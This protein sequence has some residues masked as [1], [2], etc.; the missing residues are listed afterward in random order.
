MDT[1]ARDPSAEA[2]AATMV[3]NPSPDFPQVPCRFS[4]SNAAEATGTDGVER[5]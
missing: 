2:V 3:L 4:I 5:S 1:S